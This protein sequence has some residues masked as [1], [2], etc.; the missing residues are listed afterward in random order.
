MNMRYDARVNRPVIIN[1]KS[2]NLVS[3][4]ESPLYDESIGTPGDSVRRKGISLK[5]MFDISYAVHPP[6]SN[7]KIMSAA[8]EP[9]KTKTGGIRQLTQLISSNKQQHKEGV[10]RRKDFDLNLEA[11]TLL[12]RRKALVEPKSI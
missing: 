4:V 7:E 5:E 12:R 3:K 10:H 8:N 2:I 1:P 6:R 11:A 9:I